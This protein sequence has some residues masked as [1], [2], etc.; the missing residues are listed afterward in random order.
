[1]IPPQEVLDRK[2][3]WELSLFLDSGDW[4][5]VTISIRDWT[6]RINNIIM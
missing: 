2:S 5:T 3:E 4:T 1:M 6:V